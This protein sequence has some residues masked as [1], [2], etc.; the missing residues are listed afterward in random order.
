MVEEEFGSLPKRLVGILALSDLDLS[1]RSISLVRPVEFEL[2]RFSAKPFLKT[3]DRSKIALVCD[4]I[5]VGL[6]AIS[7][8]VRFSRFILEGR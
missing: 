7:A 6:L 3:H 8:P 1:V 2:Y 5:F 4:Q